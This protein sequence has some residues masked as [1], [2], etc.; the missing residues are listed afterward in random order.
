MAALSGGSDVDAGVFLMHRAS[1]P[2]YSS[3]VC[4]LARHPG[5]SPRR[6]LRMSMSVWLTSMPLRTNGRTA[7]SMRSSTVGGY[8]RCT[9]AGNAKASSLETLMNSTVSS[10]PLASVAF[11]P[12]NL[13]LQMWNL[14]G[15]KRCFSGDR[16]TRMSCL[17]RPARTSSSPRGVVPWC[18]H[19]SRASHQPRRRCRGSSDYVQGVGIRPGW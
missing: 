9:I 11:A 8:L 7:P 16:Y 18:V 13:Y 6:S 15:M 4:S 1:L 2:L 17:H 5:G 10:A 14:F 19:P 12:A 3:G